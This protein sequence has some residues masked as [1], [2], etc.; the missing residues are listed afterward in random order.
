ML[1][2]KEKV[3]YKQNLEILEKKYKDSESKR[4]LQIFE[5]EKER[6][7][8]ALEKDNIKHE[9]DLLKDKN[10]KLASKKER[11]EKELMKIKTDFREHRKIIHSGGISSSAA[12]KEFASEKVKTMSSVD[13]SLS[14]SYKPSSRTYKKPKYSTKNYIGDK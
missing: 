7:K 3:N 1:L 4:S 2:E 9:Y 5:V 10:R 14:S 12:A 6:A 11:L 8:W 13:S